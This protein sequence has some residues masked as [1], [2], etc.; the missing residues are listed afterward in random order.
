[1]RLRMYLHMRVD[2]Y[3]CVHKFAYTFVALRMLMCTDSFIGMR[4]VIC[5]DNCIDMCHWV[6][7]S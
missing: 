6:A 2:V 7:P 4:V 3:A 5:I 1:M